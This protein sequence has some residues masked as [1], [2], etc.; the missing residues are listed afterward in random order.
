MRQQR[1]CSRTC[2]RRRRL[3]PCCR[4]PG[5]PQ[6]GRARWR[7]WPTVGLHGLVA[8]HTCRLLF[9][10]QVFDAAETGRRMGLALSPAGDVARA[11]AWLEGFL[12][13]SGLLLLHHEGLWQL[14]DAWPGGLSGTAFTQMLPLLRRTFSGFAAPGTAPAWRARRSVAAPVLVPGVATHV[15]VARADQVLLAARCLDWSERHQERVGTSSLHQP[16]PVRIWLMQ[17]RGA[18]TVGGPG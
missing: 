9:E 14:L 16:Q 10:Q 2:K 6:S 18:R 4:R 11:A 17:Q 8:G 15:D 3:S 12:H 5:K 1:T 7:G 13:G